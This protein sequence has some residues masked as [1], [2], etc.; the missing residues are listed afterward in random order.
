MRHIVECLRAKMYTGFFV[1]D[2][3]RETE[4]ILSLTLV[5][6]TASLLKQSTAQQSLFFFFFIKI[7]RK[8]MLSLRNMLWLFYAG[9]GNKGLLGE[10]K[11]NV[12]TF[13]WI[14]TL[15]VV[16]VYI[17][18]GYFWIGVELLFSW[19][20]DMCGWSMEAEWKEILLKEIYFCRFYSG[21]MLCGAG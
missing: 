19:R 3:C 5:G 18:K 8:K 17:K 7:R 4:S 13:F 9:G 14:V 21:I 6:I 11:R 15:V 12:I 10:K 1:E 16:V 20:M 2:L